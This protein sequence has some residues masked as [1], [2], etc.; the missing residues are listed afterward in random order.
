L[1][2]KEQVSKL[3]E[4]QAVQTELLSHIKSILDKLDHHM[5]GNGKPGLITRVD[6][7]EQSHKLKNAILWLLGSTVVGGVSSY[8]L[9]L[10]G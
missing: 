6:R 3:S 2:I 5:H 10:F 1:T 4:S 8:V 7:L 9:H